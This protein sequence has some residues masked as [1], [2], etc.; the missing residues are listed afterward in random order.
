MFVNGGNWGQR[1]Q[2]WF[3]E[4][5]QLR[6]STEELS[7]YADKSGAQSQKKK[8]KVAKETICER[9]EL[10]ARVKL[11][12]HH[13]V[14]QCEAESKTPKAKE[15][16]QRRCMARRRPMD[17]EKTLIYWERTL[18]D[19]WHC[20]EGQRPYST[21][22]LGITP[23]ELTT[24]GEDS[25]WERNEWLTKDETDWRECEGDRWQGEQRMGNRTTEQDREEQVEM[26][27]GIQECEHK[28]RRCHT[29]KLFH[30]RNMSFGPFLLHYKYFSE[31]MEKFTNH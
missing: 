29:V 14:E 13:H 2:Q 3:S 15:K 19:P 17:K 5:R 27:E 30:S 9:A 11:R 21:T 7:W 31:S 23:E 8:K 24:I 28:T 20:W 4:C 6:L 22:Q 25:I 12:R 1:N 16:A 26:T 18:Q 10:V